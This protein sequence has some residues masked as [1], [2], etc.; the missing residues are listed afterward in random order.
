MNVRLFQSAAKIAVC[1]LASAWCITTVVGCGANTN[2]TKGV[3]TDTTVTGLSGI[4]RGGPNP[5]TNAT[6]TLYATATVASPSSANNYGYGQ[7][8]TV[9]GTTT[10][11][12][13][14]N[15]AFTGAETACPAGQQAY[16]V[17]SG[18]YT[19]SYSAQN[20][21]ALLMAAIGPC[22]GLTEGSG[23][24]ATKVIIDEPT[25][26]A[27]AYALS[28]FMT[29]TGTASAPVVNISAPANN[30]AAV[31]SCVINST[32]EATTSCTAAGL[33]HAFLNAATLVNTTTGITNTTVTGNATAVVPQVLI[34]TL[35]NIV[36]GCVNSM[37][38][39]DTS[40]TSCTTLM[41]Y[42]TPTTYNQNVYTSGAPVPT[43]T[44]QA[45][46]FLALYPVQAASPNVDA[47][48]GPPP[49]GIMP[50]AS[51]TAVFNAAS[52]IGYYQPQLTSAPLDFTIAIYYPDG[53]TGAPWGISTDID[54]N[55]Y[56]YGNSTPPTITSLSSN[57]ATRWTTTTTEASAGGCATGG[58][59]CGT[60]PDTL[61]NLWVTDNKGVSEFNASSGA[62]IGTTY[63]PV[64]GTSAVTLDDASVD[65]GN[66]VW[67]AAYGNTAT[68]TASSL[69]EITEGSTSG[70]ANVEVNGALVALAP[71]KDPTFDPSGNMWV[72]SESGG[73]CSAALF[74]ST[75][76][77]LTAPVFGAYSGSLS[78]PETIVTLGATRINAPMIDSSGNMWIGDQDELNEVTGPAGTQ[79]A[80]YATSVDVVY[81]STAAIWDGGVERYSFMD[82]DN[83]VVVEAASG[84]F[85]FVTVYYP[86]APPD[87]YATAD[88][89][90]SGANTYL[91]PCYTAPSAT[92]CSLDSDGGSLIMNA[93][94]MATVDASGAIWASLSSGGNYIQVLGPGAPTWPQASYVP[95][96]LQTNTS[97][98][99]Y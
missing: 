68:A 84:G 53:A 30:N 34:N 61:G 91:N 35:A 33:A 47:A 83:K 77:S 11:N 82:G 85:G 99:P 55:V 25:T 7:A 71:I 58:T 72:A 5:V 21:A 36:E 88:S 62:Q 86:D 44:L 3:E 52:S 94:R 27:A 4:V 26:I 1:A 37:G 19:G 65:V 22:S 18:G 59:R 42:T 79:A 13:S 9:L 39:S 28:Q 49:T 12:A 15:F 24:T 67:V 80:G 73:C 17:S 2:F 43:N 98:R 46:Q 16:I 56:E 31:G 60:I 66:N 74:I 97:R 20:T 48:A 14:G 96:A 8:G 93:S 10:T 75:N 38:L 63:A 51:T 70:L 40:N 81:G 90:P 92:T 50:A 45:L 6:V 87:S 76:N 64:G 54:D 29:I 41:N 78:D 23:S 32:T 57:G 69:Q 89:S 95:L